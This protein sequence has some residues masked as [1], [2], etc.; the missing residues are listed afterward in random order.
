MISEWCVTEQSDRESETTEIISGI[1]WYKEER[2]RKENLNET[3]SAKSKQ[4]NGNIR[5]KEVH[6]HGRNGRK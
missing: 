6:C 1:E 5:R 4:L 2:T 3:K